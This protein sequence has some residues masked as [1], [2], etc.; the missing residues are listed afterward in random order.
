MILKEIGWDDMKWFELAQDS[1]KWQAFVNVVMK[2][3]VM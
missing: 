1:D 3:A 2:L